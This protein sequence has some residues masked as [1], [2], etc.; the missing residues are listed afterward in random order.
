MTTAKPARPDLAVILLDCKRRDQAERDQPQPWSAE[1]QL[2]ITATAADNT[3]ALRRIIEE[4]GWPGH[5]LVGEVGANA[6][7]WIAQHADHDRDFQQQSLTLLMGAVQAE[8]AAP[9][10]FANLTDRCRVHAGLPQVYGTQ[11]SHRNGELIRY[12]VEDPESLDAR[13]EELGLEPAA[14]FD[15]MIRATFL[16]LEAERAAGV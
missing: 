5:R 11:Y 7:W 15:E 13:R 6:A 2:A 12:E 8:D 4:H 14:E 3:F 16:V 9:R 10:Q 1:Q